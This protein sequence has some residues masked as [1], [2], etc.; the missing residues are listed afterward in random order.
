MVLNASAATNWQFWRLAC[1]PASR[2]RQMTRIVTLLTDGF[3]DWETS[4][5]NGAGRGFYKFDTA[6]AAPSGKPVISMGGMKVVP[7]MAIDAI[8][9]KQFDA[10]VICGGSGWNGS[11]AP[12]L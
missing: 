9:P 4:L 2:R 5:L 8:D 1:S 3:A 10:L 12:D 11:D 7:D 6:Y